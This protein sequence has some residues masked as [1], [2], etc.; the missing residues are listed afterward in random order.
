MRLSLGLAAG[1]A[2]TES[3]PDG[4]R[5]AIPEDWHQGRTA[6]GG[7]S[8]APARQ[9]RDQDFRRSAAR[10]RVRPAGWLRLHGPGD[11]IATWPVPAGLIALD[12]A[13]PRGPHP[14]MPVFLRNYFDFR[15][16]LPRSEEKQPETC[17]WVGV[18]PL[19]IRS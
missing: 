9:E 1:L 17:A 16:T 5:L 18:Y 13:T 19:G 8:T 10:R 3:L 7:L 12:E 15:F 4:F 2:V 11:D 14:L 6:Y